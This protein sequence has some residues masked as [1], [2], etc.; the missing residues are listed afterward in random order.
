MES[1]SLRHLQRSDTEDRGAFGIILLGMLS[2]S[3]FAAALCRLRVRRCEQ[4]RDSYIAQRRRENALAAALAA[5][6]N[7]TAKAL[8]QQE[9]RAYVDNFLLVEVS[10]QPTMHHAYL[11]LSRQKYHEDSEDS[12]VLDEL[13]ENRTEDASDVGIEMA[14]S[15]QTVKHVD[16]EPNC[17]ICL[18]KFVKDEEIGTSP[19][20]Q[21][22]HFYH[23]ECIL[24]WLLVNEE[25]PTCRRN[26]LELEDETSPPGGEE[27]GRLEDHL[28]HI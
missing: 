25:C 8:S 23:K 27:T 12:A 17:A 5:R 26:F 19:N 15:P 9:R 4:V 3:L 2:F 21:C 22:T 18:D 28:V 7:G 13:N 1:I 20:K 16:Q 11:I 24:E 6:E 10:T 14:S